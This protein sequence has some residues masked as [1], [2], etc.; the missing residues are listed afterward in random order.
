MPAHCR[1]GQYVRLELDCAGREDL[2]GGVGSGAGSVSQSPGA[3]SSGQ[4]AAMRFSLLGGGLSWA[5]EVT[6]LTVL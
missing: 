1:G 2:V 3:G 6:Q 5:G 4:G